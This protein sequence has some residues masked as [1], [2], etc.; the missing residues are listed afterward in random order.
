MIEAI[1]EAIMTIMMSISLRYKVLQGSEAACSQ[2][3]T[4][5]AVPG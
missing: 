3:Q 5:A 4:V 2:A 1:Q